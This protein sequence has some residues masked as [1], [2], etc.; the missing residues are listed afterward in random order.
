[1]LEVLQRRLL[2]T[3]WRPWAAGLL[4][5]SGCVVVSKPTPALFAPRVEAETGV[6]CQ[7]PAFSPDGEFVLYTRF[8]RGYND[9]PSQIVKHE[10][11]TGRERVILDG[12]QA[13][14]D[15][16]NLP[17]PCWVGDQICFASDANLLPKEPGVWVEELYTATDEG[18]IVER[19]TYHSAGDG[20][21]IE[22][23]FNPKNPNRI[24]FTWEPPG[25]G[26]ASQIGVLERDHGNRITLL[27]NHVKLTA[28]IPNWSHDGRRIVFHRW[29][30]SNPD[31]LAQ[32]FVA[33]VIFPSDGR[34]PRLANEQ[35]LAQ[36]L[37]DNTDAS[38]SMND[39]YILT[40]SQDDRTV[41][42]WALPVEG[43]KALQITHYSQPGVKVAAPSCSPD[44]RML[45]YE[46]GEPA[47][48][49]MIELP[50]REMGLQ[51]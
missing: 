22:P 2:L 47:R 41:N 49:M 13:D 14:A 18:Q 1:M 32:L 8:L 25:E 20:S 12:A 6:S 15:F 50:W 28:R 16:V 35:K 27:S 43:G 26:A 37:A 7:N 40:A 48:L 31:A 5:I 42:V 23:L 46:L 33:D 30:Q 51:K 9:G 10:L 21:C 34:P 36:R 45:L 38:W 24:L 39:R 3:A 17:G 29:D 4:A 19:L 44:G 11:R